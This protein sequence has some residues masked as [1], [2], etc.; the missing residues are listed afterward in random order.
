MAAVERAKY[1]DALGV[2][3]YRRRSLSVVSPIQEKVQHP[4]HDQAQQSGQQTNR[5]AVQANESRIDT[6]LSF[7]E[8]RKQGEQ[9][10]QSTDRPAL[11]SKRTDVDQLL[12]EAQSVLSEAAFGFDLLAW[13][14]EQ[15]LVL[16]FSNGEQDLIT[17]KHQLANNILNA[18]YG[19]RLNQAFSGVELHQYSWPID[20]MASDQAS[21]QT[22]LHSLLAGHSQH[23][24]GMPI[25]V[26]GQQG[27]SLLFEDKTAEQMS[28]MIGSKVRHELLDVDLLISQSLADMFDSAVAKAQ[29]WQLLKTLI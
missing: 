16:E 5:Q 2:V 6:L 28:E 22:W 9:Q 18:F 15:M 14:T 7:R 11:E 4:D 3:Q 26:M 27:L 13:R 1:L 20:A 25:W 23:Q 21:A 19:H 17:V 24:T 10:K 12:D 8:Q 29:A